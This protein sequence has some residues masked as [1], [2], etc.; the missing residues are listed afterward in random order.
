MRDD[1]TATAH[2]I[3]THESLFWLGIVSDLLAGISCTFLAMALYRVLKG[4]DQNLALLMVI[5]GG[6]MAAV[7]DFINVLNDVA[8]LLFARGADF[9]SVFEKPQ[10]DALVVLFLRV[11]DHGFLA[12]QFIAG[13]WLFPF[14]V[15]VFRSGFLPRILGVGLIIN[16]FSYLVISLTGFLLPQYVDR[17]FRIASPAFLGEGAIMLWLLIKGAKPQPLLAAAPA[18]AADWPASGVR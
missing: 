4:V 10:R 5:L 9:L 13:L 2:N 17:V 11:H 16:G 1:A 3:A 12:N 8:A 14:G 15:L 6:V 7:T 18:S